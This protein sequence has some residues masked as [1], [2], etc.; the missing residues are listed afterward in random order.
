MLAQTC[1][2]RFRETAA[3]NENRTDRFCH[4]C[5]TAVNFSSSVRSCR[6]GGIVSD[7]V[8]VKLRTELFFRHENNKKCGQ[9]TYIKKKI[10]IFMKNF[11]CK[12]RVFSLYCSRIHNL[13]RMKIYFP[14][15]I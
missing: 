4:F 3:R 7:N 8:Y 2:P 1:I 5:G 10:V 6:S 13:L 12:L 14:L 15:T 11:C 9:I